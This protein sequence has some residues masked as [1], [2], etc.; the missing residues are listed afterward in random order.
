MSD[1]HVSQERKQQFLAA[2]GD[3]GKEA[4]RARAWHLQSLGELCQ[5]PRRRICGAV[6]PRSLRLN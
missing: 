2:N 3:D 1:S 6:G 5:S 4:G